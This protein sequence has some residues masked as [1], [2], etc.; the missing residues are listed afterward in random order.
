MPN[1]KGFPV[2]QKTDK[3]REVL[4]S[5]FLWKSNRPIMIVLC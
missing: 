4:S 5:E 2:A 1:R 3:G